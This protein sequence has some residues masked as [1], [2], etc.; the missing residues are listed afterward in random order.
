MLSIEIHSPVIIIIETHK[1]SLDDG[2]VWIS[3]EWLFPI[4]KFYAFNT[5]NDKQMLH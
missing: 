2:W 1:F 3:F 4:W 5:K